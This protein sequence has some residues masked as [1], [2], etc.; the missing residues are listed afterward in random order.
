MRRLVEIICRKIEEQIQPSRTV[1][2][3]LESFNSPVF[4]W[5]VCARLRNNQHLNRF[6]AKMAKNKYDEFEAQRD[7]EWSAALEHILQGDNQSW[8]MRYGKPTENWYEEKSYLD[9]GNAITRWRNESAAIGNSTTALVLL[10]GT[11][12]APDTGGLSDTSYAITPRQIIEE[13]QK[14]SAPWLEPWLQQC[15]LDNSTCYG[16]WE[17]FFKTV[18]EVRNADIFQLSD[19]CD[20]LEIEEIDSEQELVDFLLSDMKDRWGI[21]PV[22]GEQYVPKVAKLAKESSKL[23]ASAVKFIDR[24]DR[25]FQKSAAAQ[26]EKKIHKFVEKHEIDVTAPFEYGDKAAD[27]S[28]FQDFSDCLTDF[29][30]GK[31]INQCRRRLMNVDYGVVDEILGISLEKKKKEKDAPVRITGEPIIAFTTIFMDALSRKSNDFG[32]EGITLTLRVTEMKLSGCSESSSDGENDNNSSVE[33]F[34][35]Q[36]CNFTG[37]ILEFLSEDPIEYNGELVRF[38]YNEFDPFDFENFS[39]LKEQTSIKTSGKWGEPC[40][41][42]LALTLTSGTDSESAKSAKPLLYQWYFSPYSAWVSAFDCLSENLISGD[43]NY[44]PPTLLL[45]DNMA[46]YLN[47]ESEDAFCMRLEQIQVHNLDA[48]YDRCIRSI[49]QGTKTLGRYNL[50]RQNFQDFAAKLIDRGLFRVLEDL[51]KTVENYSDLM[52][53]LWQHHEELNGKQRSYLPLL[54]GCFCIVSNENVLTDCSLG[55]VILPA[56]HPV[57]LEKMDAR[58]LFLRR[59]AVEQIQAMLQGQKISDVKA[60][61]AKYVK[62]AAISQGAD[63]VLRDQQ[64]T[65]M[66]CRSMWEYFGVYALPTEKKSRLADEYGPSETDG[67]G[68]PAFDTAPLAGILKR[69]ILD[70]GRTF[71]QRKDGLR[72]ALI[73]PPEVGHLVKA[74][75]GVASEWKTQ[76]RAAI[77]L[78]IITINSGADVRPYIRRWLD[79]FFDESSVLD[80]HV[81][82]H[83]L[84]VNEMGEELEALDGLLQDT[85]IC[86][87]YNI[88]TESS[89]AFA[90]SAD[91]T[92]THEEKF[93]LTMIPDTVASSSSG[94]RRVNISQ[95]QFKAS[96]YHTQASYAATPNVKDGLYRA[97]QVYTMQNKSKEILKRAHASCRWVV[98]IDRAI[99]KDL[100]KGNGAEIIGF[101]TGEGGYGELNVTVSAKKELLQDIKD[102]LARSL[103]ERFPSWEEKRCQEAAAHCMS[104]LSSRIDGGRVLKALNPRDYEIHNFLAYLLTHQIL[105]LG[106]K[107]SD[108]VLR[109]LISLDSYTHWFE[110]SGNNL[111]PDFML[112]EIPRIPENIEGTDGKLHMHIQIIECKMGKESQV[113]IGKAVEQLEEGIRTLADHWSN[114]EGEAMCRY[115]LNQLYRA[116]SFSPIQLDDNTAE[117]Q[118]VRRRIYGILSEGAEIAWSGDVYAFWLNRNED[119]IETWDCISDVPAEMEEKGV[120]VQRMQCHTYGQMFVQKKLLPQEECD[121]AIFEEALQEDDSEDA[122]DI[123][124]VV[125]TVET[126]SRPA[127]DDRQ[128][129]HSADP[130][131]AVQVRSQQLADSEQ[132]ALPAESY[133]TTQLPVVFPPDGPGEKV[134]T[135]ISSK[136]DDLVPDHPFEEM[137]MEG[138]R[139]QR[140]PIQQVRLLLGTN[141]KTRE[142]FYWEF[143]NKQLANRHLL[144]NGNSGCGKTYC[145]QGL[146][147]EAALQ[148]VSAI[149]FDYTGG[150]A[151]G[152]LEKVF[153]DTL[154]KQGKLQQRI[155]KKDKI[156]VNPFVKGEIQIDEDI[157]VQEEN[158][159][160]ADKI[161][162]TFKAVY[163]LGDQQRSAVYTAV[164]NAMKMR[165]ENMTFQDMAAELES[166]GS[167]Q[168]K[169]VLSKIQTFTDFNPF[170]ADASFDWSQIRDSDGMVY[171]FQLAG[172]GR[173]I[174]ILLTE[175]LLWDIWHFCVKTGNEGKPLILVLDEAQ[176]LNHGEKSPSRKI[177]TEGRKFGIA[178]WYATQF[179]K[180]Q[181]TDIE[182][183]N[184]QQAAQMLYFCPPN[185]GVQTVAKNIAMTASDI[186]TWSERLKKLKKGECITCGSMERRGRWEKYDPCMIKICSIEERIKEG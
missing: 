55:D 123:E 47:C 26:V 10:M 146:L 139:P 118:A 38:R 126:E 70:Y 121:K 41:I 130:I 7:A 149:V 114:N 128:G 49:Y 71:P 186:K 22:L 67:D 64:M 141:P 124:E 57:V 144:I 51:R 78:T 119:E 182:I 96:K 50:L 108:Y 9:T 112:L 40:R 21:P 8:T 184:L 151:P 100:L 148:G 166:I 95:F 168:A 111:R 48:D 154:E 90:E 169:S 81:Y 185:E 158:S 4:Y 161:A 17:H 134:Q 60:R 73:A 34:Y 99:D 125:P 98:C 178:G 80:I 19:L 36:I 153:R 75:S 133:D 68:E 107:K 183:Q 56:W 93:P 129:S 167:S 77:Y 31:N 28:D 137:G 113:H 5:E 39:R 25:V 69:N 44:V 82:L 116:V 18:F 74:L 43:K 52:E 170:A 54:L 138:G 176:N 13:F 104:L 92:S 33:D 20:A 72:I 173:E 143:G 147:M 115:W 132:S 76:G 163:Q 35:Q 171:V 6:V 164:M 157:T 152:K 131:V 117:Y 102:M 88:L 136:I 24:N 62:L 3:R 79:K 53:Y 110:D 46:D 109:E 145:I 85:D 42:N 97:F 180:P 177:L 27:F 16:V 15:G 150:F 165:G 174:Q 181:L 142:K 89:I 63:I 45:C 175:L 87:N 86:F 58:Q 32:Q 61:F 106:E 140:K 105:E 155:V 94:K 11:E 30:Q 101:T 83:S 84:S 37:G 103:R 1:V 156:P 162:E 23:I 65:K 179:M 122:H 172:Y 120:T 160:V 66:T 14:N 2:L 127:D 12:A 159:D 29:V 91:E 59:G 135:S